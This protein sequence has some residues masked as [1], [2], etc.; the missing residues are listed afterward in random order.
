VPA[1]SPSTSASST[2]TDLPEVV[3][4]VRRRPL[5]RWLRLAVASLLVVA[6]VAPFAA[7]VLVPR[8]RVDGL[9]ASGVPFV[10]GPLHVLI[11]GSD[12]R[13]DLSV[14]ERI[15][16][17]TGSAGGERADTIILL[18]IHGG[19]AGLLSFPRD[20]SVERCD[21]SVGRINGALSIGGPSCLVETVHR[22]TG[23]RA[24]HHVSVT[25]GGFRDVVDAVGGVE[26]CLERAIRDRS[27]GIDLPEGCQVLDGTDALG[28]VRVRKIDSDFARIGRQQQFLRALAGELTDPTLL[29]RPWRLV[30]LVVGASRAVGVDHRLGPVDLARI[31]VGMRAVASGDAVTAT[32][33]ADGFTSR[34]GAAMLRVRSAEA[35]PIFAGFADGTALSARP[36][37]DG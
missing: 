22:L 27:A 30:P 32:V 15:A 16:L 33:P 28:F 5:L 19:R 24:H 34:G 18:T 29:V 23:I 10:G 1:P 21:G 14:E 25:F 36:V 26:L 3:V 31:A 9:A 13:A 7:L 4:R 37:T 2:P 17:T 12:S 8:E 20:L 35:G 11:T 6:L